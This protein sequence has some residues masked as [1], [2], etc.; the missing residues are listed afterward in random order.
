MK[1]LFALCAVICMGSATLLAAQGDRGAG[2][3]TSMVETY[4]EPHQ[5]LMYPFVSSSWDHN[6][7]YQPTMFGF[8]REQDFRGHCGSLAP[9][10]SQSVTHR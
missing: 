4:V 10:A 9:H 3:R 1:Q 2:I 6:F 5:L 8:A 7:E